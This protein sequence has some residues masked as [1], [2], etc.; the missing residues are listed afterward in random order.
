MK[1]QISAVNIE[2]LL[3]VSFTLRMT[4]KTHSVAAVKCKDSHAKIEQAPPQSHCRV[5]KHKHEKCIQIF[6]VFSL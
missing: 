1:Q 5:W 6:K 3:F 2:V 4:N